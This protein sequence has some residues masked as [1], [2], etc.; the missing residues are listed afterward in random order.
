MEPKASRISSYLFVIGLIGS[1]IAGVLVHELYIGSVGQAWISVVFVV[2][3]LV[4]GFFM[5][6]V[7]KVEEEIYILLLVMV[8]LLIASNMGIFASFNTATGTNLGDIINSI[9]GYIAVFS[10]AAIIMLA[11]R[12]ITHF[13]VSKIS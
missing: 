13:H 4:I 6:V 7:K 12:T 3:G 9:V 1:L 5:P 11:I 2:I 8:A 10:A